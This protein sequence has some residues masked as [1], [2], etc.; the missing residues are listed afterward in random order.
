MELDPL[1]W[2]DGHPR[3][4]ADALPVEG[5]QRD[6]QTDRQR[7]RQKERER[8]SQRATETE[9]QTDRQTET[10]RGRAP[11]ERVQLV[12]AH[13]VALAGVLD[14]AAA[15]AATTRYVTTM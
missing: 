2:G 6:R 10:E 5:I 15:D 7:D 1:G 13:L 8:Q 12:R 4:G 3:D 14:R 9:R 11:V